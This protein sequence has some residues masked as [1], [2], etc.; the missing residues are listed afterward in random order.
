MKVPPEED[1]TFILH[2]FVHY[3]QL[4]PE[5]YSEERIK[6]ALKEIY[7]YKLWSRRI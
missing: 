5:K 6:C 1:M 3:R 2:L 4:N 7:N